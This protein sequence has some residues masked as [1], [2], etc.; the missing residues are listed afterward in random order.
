MRKLCDVYERIV[1]E[2]T[3]TDY[4]QE[5]DVTYADSPIQALRKYVKEKVARCTM[6][7]PD[8]AYK[9]VSHSQMRLPKRFYYRRV[10]E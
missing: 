1:Y 9:V 7:H 5:I 6:G 3:G 4:Y 10:S 2:P 8:I